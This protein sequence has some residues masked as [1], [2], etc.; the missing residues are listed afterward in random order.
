MKDNFSID[1]MCAKY[2]IMIGTFNPIHNGHLMMANYLL[3]NSDLDNIVIVPS[4]GSFGKPE[5]IDFKYRYEMISIALKDIQSKRVFVSDRELNLSGYT[6]DTLD[7]FELN[8]SLIIGADNFPELIKFHR[9]MDIL[10]NYKI[11]VLDRNGVDTDS[12][13]SEELGKLGMTRSDCKGIETFCN[14]PETK[15]SSS[16]IRKQVKEGKSIWGYV[17]NRVSKYI[18]HNKLY[19]ENEDNA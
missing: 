7:S 17:P 14:F 12:M 18:K 15:I 9:S 13:I 16:F 11:Y 4:P 2:G 10:K 3:E 8:V 6:I 5:L 19:I 1:P